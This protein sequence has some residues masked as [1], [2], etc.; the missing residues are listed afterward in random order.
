MLNNLF[1]IIVTYN[2][3][4]WIS[5]CLHNTIPYHVIIIDNNSSDKTVEIIKKEYPHV[6]LIEAGKNLGFGKANNLGFQYALKN[7]A[8]YVFLLNQDAYLHK[9]CIEN[10]ISAQKNSPEY[11]VLSP[12]HLNGKGNK[13]DRQFS[14]YLNYKKNQFFYS[15][16]VLD[17]PKKKIYEVPFVNA[18]GWLISKKC[19]NTVGGFDPIF[20]HYGED[21]NYCQRLRYHNFKIGIVPNS[22]L[23]HDREFRE[24]VEIFK[25]NS[26]YL[27]K[28]EI[29]IKREFADPNKAN[30]SEF[31][32]IIKTSKIAILKSL[33]KID[34]KEFRYRKMEFSLLKKIRPEIKNSFISTKKAGRTYLSDV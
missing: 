26:N 34:I 4:Q 14:Y 8:D 3:E 7:N 30:I 12:I 9:D 27:Q 16:F 2:G 17:Q 1:I 20:F 10:L 32:Q 18:A 22:Y 15:D 33:L 25:G 28:K 29:L 11:G 13:L 5:K 24:E 6:H 21:D 19:L 23:R 31:D